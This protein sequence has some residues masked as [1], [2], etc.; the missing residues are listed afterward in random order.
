[1]AVSSLMIC[2]DASSWQQTPLTGSVAY[3][4]HSYADHRWDFVAVDD[5]RLSASVPVLI[6]NSGASSGRCYQDPDQLAKRLRT[7]DT[8]Y[9]LP[10][11]SDKTET[12]RTTT[13]GDLN[14]KYEALDW[15]YIELQVSGKGSYNIQSQFLIVRRLLSYKVTQTRPSA[16]QIVQSKTWGPRQLC[17]QTANCLNNNMD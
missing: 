7:A 4:C 13:S 3:Y 14:T 10:R 8:W 1:M 17:S 9:L 5:G 11:L 12:T 6:P 16:L 2:V 15:D